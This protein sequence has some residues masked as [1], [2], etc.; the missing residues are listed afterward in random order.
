TRP[1]ILPLNYPRNRTTAADWERVGFYPIGDGTT[2]H[3]SLKSR[4]DVR[5]KGANP[6]RNTVT[7]LL[8]A[9][10]LQWAS[11]APAMAH[12]RAG[13]APST[14][15]AQEPAG[16]A[17]ATSTAQAEDPRRW[18]TSEKWVYELT[19]FLWFT[20]L[21]TTTTLGPLTASGSIS[22]G[23]IVQNLEGG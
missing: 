15:S 14:A 4:R 6:V 5:M 13:N 19:P 20:G 8:L 2:L 16:N 21:S 22:F 11:M 23:D 10:M 3:W 9:G 17:P 7:L 18:V 1:D 12:D